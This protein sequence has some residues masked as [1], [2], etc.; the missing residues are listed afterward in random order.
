[1]YQ[2][3]DDLFVFFVRL[4]MG[5]IPWNKAA[6]HKHCQ[7]TGRRLFVC[8]AEDRIQGCRLTLT[9]HHGVAVRCAGVVGDG[10]WN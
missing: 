3:Y 10:K 9:E 1:M 8:P 6:I 2:I 7:S 5:S 4:S